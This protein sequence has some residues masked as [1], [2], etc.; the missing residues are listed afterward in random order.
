[1]GRTDRPSKAWKSQLKRR[2]L[3]CR[4]NWPYGV[5]GGPSISGNTGNRDVAAKC[6]KWAAR[7]ALAAASKSFA[8]GRGFDCGTLSCPGRHRQVS[9]GPNCLMNVRRQASSVMTLAVNQTSSRSTDTQG[10]PGR[11][12]AN[13]SSPTSTAGRQFQL[14]NLIGDNSAFCSMSCSPLFRAG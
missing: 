2:R 12:T 3:V 8:L 5:I 7:A 1:M 6:A 10:S 11:S 4:R 14:A 13:A 9:K